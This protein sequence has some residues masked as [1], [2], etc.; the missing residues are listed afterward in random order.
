V[1]QIRLDRTEDH[2]RLQVSDD[3]RGG[4]NEAGNGVSGMRARVAA[5]GGEFSLRSER[6]T[7]VEAVLPLGA[8]AEA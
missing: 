8:G 4:V 7:V 1:C 2:V 5:L 6:G 3:G